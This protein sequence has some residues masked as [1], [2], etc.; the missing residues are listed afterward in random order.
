MISV[1]NY[2]QKF[3]T[4]F[5]FLFFFSTVAQ[6][7][8]VGSGSYTKSFPGVDSAGRNGY[9]SGSP[10]ISGNALGKPIPTNDWWS[11]LIK[12]N[13]ASNL[14]N[15]PYTLKT[16][17]NGLV[18]SYIPWGVIDDMEP[19]TVGVNG[20]SASKTTIAD[21][22][23]WIVTMD[24]NNQFQA[25]AG[26]GMPFLYFTKGSSN[27]AKI[28]VNSGTVV[29]DNE[30]IV[31][32]N[33]K[34]GA[35]FAVYAPVG[36]TWSQSG[37][38]YTSSL[39]GKNY[40]SMAFIPLT[41][42]NV[43]SVAND[44]KK[45][46]YVFPTNT[47]STY[48]YDD[49]NAT[50]RTDFNVSTDVKEGSNT[51]VLLG[52]LPH[53]WANLAGDSPTPSEFSY[54]TIRGELKT[55]NSNSFSVENKFYGILPTLPYLNNYSNGFDPT[56]LKDKITSLENDALNPWTDSYNE[57]QMMNRLIQTARI[58]DK[59]GNTTALNKIIAT[60]KERLE[61]WLKADNGEVAFLFYYNTTWS[62]LLGYPAGHGQD[63]N[64]NDHHFHW[65]YFIHAASFLEQYEPGW[66]NQWGPMVDLLVR[67]AASIDRNDDLFPYLRN[68][69]P[70][71]G[72]CWANGFATFPQG[73]DQESTSESMQFN[74]S[75]IHWGEV[76]GNTAIRDLGI[77]LYTTEQT[78]I[79]EY[80]LDTE[81]RNFPSSQQYSLV[82][83]IWGNSLDNGTFWTAD[84]AASYGIEMYPIH[85]GSLYLG[86]DTDYVTKLWNEIKSNTG[87][88][89]N[90]TNA[91]LWHDVMWEYLAFIDPE[92]AIEMYDSYPN[93]ELKFGVS[94]AQT[95]H[96]LHA[97]N[98][99]GSVNVSITADHPIAAAFI[100]N[101]ETT[102]VAHNYASQAKT[103]TFSDGYQLLVPAR[104]MVTSKD[105]NVE[106]VLTS[107][108]NQAAVNGIVQLD[109]L[110]S[111]GSPSKVE[112]MDGNTSLG[113]VNTAP[114]TFN[115]TNLSLGMHSFYARIYEGTSF[116]SS[117][118]VEVQVGEQ[119]P[120]ENTVWNIPGVIEAGKFDV[121]EGGKGQNIAYLDLSNSNNGDYRMDES[122]D[123][124]NQGGSE[125]VSV[126]WIDIGEWLEYT[127]NVVQSGTYSMGFRYASANTSGGGPFHIEL[128][129][130]TVSNTISVPSTSNSGNWYVWQTKTVNNIE[131]TPGEHV[132][133]L[134]FSGGEF[135]LGKMTFTRTGS[136]N[137]SYPVADAGSNATVQLP[138]SSVSLNGSNSTESAGKS[139]SY[140]WS[141]NYG[142]TTLQFSSNT[143]AMSS[144][145][146]L[147]E[148]IYSLQLMVTNT[149]GETDIDEVLLIVSDS[150]NSNP[151]ISI[152]S[153]GSN[154]TLTEGNSVEIK[155]NASD[156]DG[157]VQRV[158]FYQNDVLISS[159]TSAPFIANWT[160]SA[161]TYTLTAKAT[162][163][164]GAQSTSQNVV[165]TIDPSMVCS[166]TS[167]QATQGSFSAGYTVTYETIGTDVV[168][169]FELLDNKSGVV[170]Y[171]WKESP[172]SESMM[173]HIEGQTFRMVLGGQT[174]GST[175][176]YA[177]KF[178]FSGGMSV[179][180]YMQYVVGAD[181]NGSTG[182]NTGGGNT[183]GGDTST[184]ITGTWVLS[185]EA[186]ALKVGPS[187]G[188][189]DWWS[190]SA[191]DLSTRACYMDDQY[192]FAAN[193]SFTNVLGADTWLEGW[194][195][196]GDNCGTP[197]APHDGS[198]TATYNYNATAGTLTLN[199]QGA[200]IGLP[201]AYNGGELG[202]PSGAP[203][204]ITYE[205]SFS[206]NNTMIVDINI[207][208]GWWQYKLVKE[209]DDTGGNDT[210]GGDSLGIITLFNPPYP[211]IDNLTWS[212]N[213]NIQE[214]GDQAYMVL[215]NAAIEAILNPTDFSNITHLKFDYLHYGSV[216][217]TITF[218][219]VNGGSSS[220]TENGT[221]SWVTYEIPMTN[222]TGSVDLS[223]INSVTFTGGSYS[224]VKNY[225]FYHDTLNTPELPKEEIEF[226]PNP[227]SGKINV[228]GANPIAVYNISG[229][230]VLEG[231]N[232][233]DLSNLPNGIYFV[234]TN[235]G[236]VLKVIK[237]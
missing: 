142:P 124:E 8:S 181:C 101:G 158:D 229:Q 103:V 52:L 189:G 118:S 195:G 123:A 121:F 235:K 153:P 126:G 114:F 75:L 50:I 53:Q 12:E 166:E 191:G 38:T 14:F 167:T 6:N 193:G 39:N 222:F 206:D 125:G 81:E 24:W 218:T 139:L 20:V 217:P 216:D 146:G 86:H 116:N 22:S 30:M 175:I 223:A 186:G 2:I 76:T 21:Y 140:Y 160:P 40:W 110:I 33:A 41:A 188:N 17:S 237:K 92:K 234:R 138:Q 91:N 202:S 35:D 29:V 214:S 190:L 156:Y 177:C 45:Y 98:A 60:V 144:V 62:A 231:V 115:A 96:W 183:G 88:L 68:F 111:Q 32:S 211:S 1:V 236:V 205:V 197:V 128:D 26:I 106:G 11:S 168:I 112:F 224:R 56:L 105:I 120:Y 133:R 90:Q 36:S 215:V 74:S 89:S 203:N 148:G 147:V 136:M 169:T 3:S 18:V 208:S 135:N 25:T 85:G 119:L 71:A 84:I 159:D 79:E 170:A 227:T 16:T 65:G 72:H 155:A 131:L 198:N 201:K 174:V 64:I 219:D 107:S 113:V 37:S 162:D 172:F 192:I 102:Y 48:N 67:D 13:H 151:V 179:T 161:G 99:L 51:N 57:G 87:I 59:M 196:G 209:S 180:E 228:I 83:R 200:Y 176:S 82:S 152:T 171:L 141:Q 70:Y 184:G 46:A 187:Q 80:W 54:A 104:E 43:T 63:S 204:S 15:Y 77:Y 73:N 213:Q 154:T 109:L 58:A 100:K 230:K 19:I 95:Y 143:S 226:S 132:L 127:V 194:Q 122:V 55:L 23:D 221:S 173:Q 233:S 150:D 149:D 27:L 157:I 199:G 137:N 129:G 164:M 134:V 108:F 232:S 7:V 9:P 5:F 97:M 93:R 130:K 178:A 145:S 210:G 182:G 207:G 117:N 220:Y 66:V 42:S 34:N 212:V 28:T 61:D 69:S 47:T 10:Q 163:D 31:I 4:L 49:S 225:Y 185:P 94:D 44:Y 78:A 165:I